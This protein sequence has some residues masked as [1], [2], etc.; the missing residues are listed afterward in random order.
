[1]LTNLRIL[2]CSFLTL[3]A[4]AGEP[5]D[6]VGDVD[7]VGPS[8]LDQ[9]RGRE[10]F[11]VAR[12]GPDGSGSFVS[13]DLAGD[14]AGDIPGV[15]LPVMG[16]D[17]V[18]RALPDGTVQIEELRVD[19]ADVVLDEQAFPPRGLWLSGLAARLAA[20][21]TTDTAWADDGQAAVLHARFDL[22][23]DWGVVLSDGEVHPLATQVLRDLEL[24]V[25]VSRQG[26]AGLRLGLAAH[27][28]GEVWSW[29]QFVEVS[30]LSVDLVGDNAPID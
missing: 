30:N 20:P 19:L 23:F 2:A 10:S 14:L 18:A 8:V 1:M 11:N 22:L 5:T 15:V 3:G 13:A 16:G 6:Y 26:P 24:Q 21:I 4:C 17:V 7:P 25:E 28:E 12:T 27:A 29:G 9:M